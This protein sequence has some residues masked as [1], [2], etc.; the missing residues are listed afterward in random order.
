MGHSKLPW[1]I[2]TI[3]CNGKDIS[4]NDKAPDDCGYMYNG[5]YVAIVDADAGIVVDNADYYP[6]P[7]SLEN[8]KLIVDS[9]N[10]N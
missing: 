8:A 4:D 2:V 6:Q 9:V 3:E 1:K 5:E 10:K 7:V